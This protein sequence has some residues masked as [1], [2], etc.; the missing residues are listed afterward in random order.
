MIKKVTLEKL[1]GMVERGFEE[2]RV[3]IKDVRTHMVTKEELRETREVL[4]RAIKDL[5]LR[6]VAWVG[7]TQEEVDGLKNW[8]EGIEARVS[9]LEGT[10]HRKTG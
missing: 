3:E 2:V 10:R 9:T 1:A 4:A 7:H 8:M 5:D 6:L